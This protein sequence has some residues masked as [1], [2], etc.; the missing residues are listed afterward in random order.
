MAEIL[1]NVLQ[2]L[3]VNKEVTKDNV[4]FRIVT[5]GSFG[6]FMLCSIL[7]GL[8]SYVSTPITCDGSSKEPL[9]E[10]NCWLHGSYN[11]SSIYLQDENCFKSE[12]HFD[13]LYYNFQID[14]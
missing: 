8:T 10:I 9:M 11:L 6:I 2:Y 3:K 12:V 14:Y 4:A 1:K 5:V 7:N 13:R